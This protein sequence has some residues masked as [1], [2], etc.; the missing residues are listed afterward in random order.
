[1][2]IS[3]YATP[4]TIGYLGN[5]VSIRSGFNCYNIKAGLREIGCGGMDWIDKA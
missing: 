3:G 5:Y 1:M 2:G 4:L